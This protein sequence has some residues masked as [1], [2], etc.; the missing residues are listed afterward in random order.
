M[1]VKSPQSYVLSPT[2]QVLSPKSC[3]KCIGI[4]ILNTYLLFN[5][6]PFDPSSDLRD[7]RLRNLDF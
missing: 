6:Q 2:S 4:L 3:V 7:R 5:E 1:E